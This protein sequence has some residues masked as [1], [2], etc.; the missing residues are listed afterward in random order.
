MPRKGLPKCDCGTGRYADYW[1]IK[2]CQRY[3]WIQCQHCGEV[4]KTTSK[5]RF[6]VHLEYRP[7]NWREKL[8][9]F[10]VDPFNTGERTAN[11]RRI[12]GCMY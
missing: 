1:L 3:S 12:E 2:E 6:R 4:R 11:A 5:F 10:V 9:P 8:D 7:K